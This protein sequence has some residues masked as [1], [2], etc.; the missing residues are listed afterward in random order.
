MSGCEEKDELLKSWTPFDAL[1][2]FN[3]SAALRGASFVS[4]LRSHVFYFLEIWNK[5]EILRL[6]TRW[7]F[8]F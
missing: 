5:T 7:F 3:S 8:F 6:Y 1:H 2:S 4:A